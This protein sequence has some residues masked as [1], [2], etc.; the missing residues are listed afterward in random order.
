MRLS[1]KELPVQ[2]LLVEI[3]SIVLGV[4]LALAVVEGS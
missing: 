1:A 2:K 3:F 4:L